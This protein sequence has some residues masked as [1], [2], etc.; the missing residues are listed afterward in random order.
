MKNVS[1]DNP[2]LL[3]I[4]IPLV[5]A[6]V[7]PFVIA[8]GKA[9]KGKG[10]IASL[11]L[12]ILIAA[13]ASIAAANPTRTTVITQT[14]VIVV[15]DASYSSHNNLSTIDGYI[16]EIKEKLPKNSSLGLVCFADGY[17]LLTP[18]GGE[19][20]SVTESTVD[21]GATEISS[22]LDYAATLFGED[23]IKRVVLVTDGKETAS[24][25]TAKLIASVENL[26]AKNIYLDAIYVDNN[27]SADTQEVQ[28]TG[29]EVKT[30]TYQGHEATVAALVQSNNATETPSTISLYQGDKLLKKR[31]QKLTRGYNVVN[32]DLP[33]DEEGEFDYEVRVDTADDTADSSSYNNAYRFTQTVTGK[34]DV[35]LVS[36]EQAD[37]ALV[38]EIYGDT[39]EIHA[40]IDKSVVPCVVEEL[41]EYDEIVLSN[42][43][44]L[45]DI[46]NVTAFV[47]AV[48]K[49]VSKFGKSLITLGDTKIQDA[50]DDK[51]QKFSD[52]LPVR[53]GNS[54]Q[55]KKVYTLV[56]DQ[57]RSLQF[58]W[59]LDMMKEAA[60]QLVNLLSPEDEVLVYA[61][62][63]RID[64][65]E[66]CGKVKDVRT[67]LVQE[68][69]DLT[70]LQGTFIGAA[71]SEAKEDMTGDYYS[72]F[73]EKQV[74]LISDGM[75]YTQEE[76]DPVKIVEEMQREHNIVTSV[77]NV[78]CEE[79][80]STMQA[81]AEAGVPEGEEPRY[82]FLESLDDVSDLIIGEVANEVTET[83]IEEYSPTEIKDRKDASVSGLT[84]LPGVYGF[85]SSSKKADATVVLSAT[86]TRA[87]GTTAEMPLYA[88]HAHG[89][90][91]VA[92]FTSTLTGAWTAGWTATD[93]NGRA[94]FGNMLSANTPEEKVA[95]PYT[96][97]IE[98]DGTYSTVQ[99]TPATLKA[100]GVATA[101]I[102]MPDGTK[103]TQK[104]TFDST[105]YFYKFET[106][107][108]GKYSV[109]ITYTYGEESFA[110]HAAFNISYS[111][112]YDSF[113]V[114]NAGSLY[115]TVRD[116]GT[117]TENA[118]PSL[119]NDEKEVATYE[120]PL[121]PALMIAA[122][123]LFTIDI[124]VRKLRWK[125]ITSLFKRKKKGGAK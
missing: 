76:D 17:E 113:A 35:L 12:H 21:S 1:F 79:G 120:Q 124:V 82:Y 105:K 38:E 2:Y 109:D 3:L 96:T 46:S 100:D 87:S 51:L 60:I 107:D 28:L 89:N 39:A 43:D 55:D 108:E 26:Y 93:S 101:V 118:V 48:D 112:E 64:L 81:I 34:L 83:I 47:D 65:L 103:T 121:A 73:K 91:R 85:V 15:A 23:V 66:N 45:N 80:A 86:Y 59:H 50:S 8:F 27:I 117:V 41:C 71:L 116:R 104:L 94:F 125:D 97:N 72:S 67:K 31:T 40:Y 5:I 13:C 111:P 53:F 14:Q 25:A 88:Y 114:Y 22:A 74:M 54:D 84:S 99:I 95:C 33:T 42:I 122:V 98:Y 6:I 119:D 77:I 70:P 24:D 57:S 10:V 7:I 52:M 115:S 36:T 16:G 32:F 123:V 92:S 29:V 78:D 75:S 90:G 63:G 58:A 4:F 68:I 37:Q 19:L 62:S 9:H 49:A 30:S 18:L 106:P 61:F 20:K 69:R 56:I 11:V 44:I 110:S 102:T